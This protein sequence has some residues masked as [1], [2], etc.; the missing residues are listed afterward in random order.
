MERIDK[1]LT[2]FRWEQVRAAAKV[3]MICVY[4][5]P[6]DYPGKYVARLWD[7]Q[8]PTGFVVVADSLEQIREAIPEGMV[9]FNRSGEDDPV[10][11]ETWI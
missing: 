8:R 11:V 10:I 5:N 2:A 1:I 6:A 4:E 9:P 3:P 7:L